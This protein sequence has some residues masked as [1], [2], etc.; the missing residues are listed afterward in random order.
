MWLGHPPKAVIV[1]VQFFQGIW[2][3][4][5]YLAF[6]A[7]MVDRFP[8]SAGTAAAATSITQGAL[9]ASGVVVLQPLLMAVGYRWCFKVLWL[10]NCIF[11][12][13]AVVLLRLRGME[14]RRALPN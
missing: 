2:Q 6:N 7:L 8:N 5:V 1:I 12:A 10:C 11:R 4:N 13:G 3:T 9:A 14:W